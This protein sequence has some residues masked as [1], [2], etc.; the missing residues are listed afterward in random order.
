MCGI[1]GFTKF[2]GRA[3][4]ATIRRMTA[5]LVHRG[6]DQQGSYTADHAGLGAVR[7]QVIDPTGG[8]QPIR[9]EDGRY[10]IVYNGEIY[11]FTE[12]RREL[13]SLGQ[14][15]RSNCDTEVALR[16]FAQ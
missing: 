13:E 6:P 14:K 4:S 2:K 3:D 12:L 10:V 9:T 1:A 8:E 11:N 7:L 5:S 15:F 16:A